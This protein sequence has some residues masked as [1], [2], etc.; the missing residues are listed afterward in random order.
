MQCASSPSRDERISKKLIAIE[1]RVEDVLARLS[2]EAGRTEAALL[3]INAAV[4]NLASM[5]PNCS[6]GKESRGQADCLCVGAEAGRSSSQALSFGTDRLRSERN[7]SKSFQSASKEISVIMRSDRSEAQAM[8]SQ[9]LLKGKDARKK[10]NSLN[11]ESIGIPFQERLARAQIALELDSQSA[12]SKRITEFLEDPDSSR[13]AGYYSYGITIFTSL[14]L[15][16]SFLPA[17]SISVDNRDY[18]D[19][20]IDLVLFAETAV[21]FFFYPNYWAIITGEQRFE[22]MIDCCSAV[23]LILIALKDNFGDLGSLGDAALLAA[24]PM[25]RLLRLV[26]RFTYMQLLKAAFREALEALPV[27]LFCL[28]VMAYG[29]AALLY[30]VEPRENMPTIAHAAWLVIST[31]TTVGFGDVVPSTESG[32]FLTSIL[33][34]VS[35]LYMAMPLAVIGHSFNTIWAHRKR[36]LLLNKTRSRLHKWGFGAYEMPRLFGLFDLDQSAEVDLPEFQILLREMDMGFKEKEITELFKLIDKDS[37][38]T[39]DEKEFVK[40]LY[41]DEY[42]LLYPKRRVS[43]LT[44]SLEH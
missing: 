32:L 38:G 12:T 3:Q 23:P 5:L 21:R 41:P 6:N 30:L 7:L 10:F 35:S 33:M 28:A 27:L 40:T 42:R 20:F 43:R 1:Q 39:I 19:F 25:I 31:I 9:P 18:V 37:G 34:V 15:L 36:I 29:F 22:N 13:L 2:Q 14:G 16:F 11:M 26:R 4:T 17:V 24:M 44:S 8:E